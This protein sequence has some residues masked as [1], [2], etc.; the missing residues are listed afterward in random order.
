M[1]TTLIS[2]PPELVSSVLAK[3]EPRATLYNLARCSRQLY[4]FTLPILNCD[5]TIHELGERQSGQLH[6]LASLLI[7]QPDLAKLVRNVTLHVVGLFRTEADVSKE[8][9]DFKYF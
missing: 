3:I 7:R 4:I 6:E 5:V 1:S 8:I 2:L 9:K